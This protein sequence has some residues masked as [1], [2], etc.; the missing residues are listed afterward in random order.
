MIQD[1]FGEQNAQALCIRMQVE[2]P[3]P[4]CRKK[5]LYRLTR[6]DYTFGHALTRRCN[7]SS[8]SHDLHDQRITRAATP[9]IL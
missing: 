7:E 1:L 5:L 4:D 3:Y 6:F 2:F 9:T 8:Q